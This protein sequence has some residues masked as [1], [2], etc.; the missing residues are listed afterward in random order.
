MQAHRTLTWPSPNISAL[1]SITIWISKQSANWD[2]FNEETN[3]VLVDFHSQINITITLI[4]LLII[5]FL[6]ENKRHQIYENNKTELPY[7]VVKTKK[8]RE[9]TK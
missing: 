5:L 3:E 1:Q 8:P 9:L 7:H 4:S 2:K 6:Q